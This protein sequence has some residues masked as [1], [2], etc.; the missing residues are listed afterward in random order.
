[1]TMK[2]EAKAVL[3][4]CLELTREIAARPDPDPW[5]EW[6]V[7]D[8][9]DERKYG[10]R[11][12]PA[13]WFGGGK[14]LREAERVRYLRALQSLERDGL[15]KITNHAGGTKLGW[16]KLTDAGRAEAEKLEARS[17]RRKPVERLASEAT[18]ARG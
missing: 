1:M 13:W 7:A 11:Y 6:E 9:A 14:P 15:V 5:K 16:V 10:P 4:A 12:W 18:E 17:A 8:L 2:S 3:L